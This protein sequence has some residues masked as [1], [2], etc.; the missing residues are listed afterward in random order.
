[1][2]TFNTVLETR[3]RRGVRVRLPDQVIADRRKWVESRK[4]FQGRRYESGVWTKC[5]AHFDEAGEVQLGISPAESVHASRK[6]NYISNS[7]GD[8]SGTDNNR[9]QRH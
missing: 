9:Q 2:F 5:F 4:T 3:T 7:Q 1:M 6:K 8:N